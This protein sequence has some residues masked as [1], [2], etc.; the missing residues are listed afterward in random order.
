MNSSVCPLPTTATVPA[1]T[2]P[3]CDTCIAPAAV[4]AF[5]GLFTNRTTGLALNETPVAPF[6]GRWLTTEPCVVS[7]AAAVVNS[8]VNAARALPEIS[9]TVG[10]IASVITVD[11]GRFNPLRTTVRLSTE[12][13]VLNDCRTPPASSAMFPAEDPPDSVDG[14]IDFENTTTT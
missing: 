5:S 1:T 13:L 7:N 8:L 2:W 14:F 11:A 6:A 12:M 10:G 3:A 9:V 4:L